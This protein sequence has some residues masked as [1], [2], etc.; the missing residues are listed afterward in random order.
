ME[1]YFQ[2]GREADELLALRL[3]LNSYQKRME[4]I[5]SSRIP[6]SFLT[7]DEMRLMLAFHSMFLQKYCE[8]SQRIGEQLYF[9]ADEISH[10]C[11]ET[12]ALRK[13]I[14]KKDT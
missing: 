2:K 8:Q 10:M 6:F 1:S 12:M 7:N 5:A 4:N 3:F 13:K 14:E 11:E 9:L